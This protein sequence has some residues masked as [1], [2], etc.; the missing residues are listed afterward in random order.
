MGRSL[1]QYGVAAAVTIGAL[2][3]LQVSAPAAQNSGAS[4][5][6]EAKPTPRLA[7]GKP[8]FT[9]YFRSS[10]AGAGQAGEQ[11]LTKTPDGSAFYAYGGATIGA[12]TSAAES[13][14][15]DKNPAPYKPEYK[16]KADELLK[17]AYGPRDNKMDPSLYCKP[18]GVVR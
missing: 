13:V 1:K 17:Y 18:N 12:E 4:A 7:N 5:K 15:R 16:A 14:A 10:V 3:F 8:D 6:A 2:C 9:G 11:V